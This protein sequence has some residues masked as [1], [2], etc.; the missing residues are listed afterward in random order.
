MA[1]ALWCGAVFAIYG[2]ALSVVVMRWFVE[3]DALSVVGLIGGVAG[4]LFGAALAWFARYCFRRWPPGD[5]LAAPPPVRVLVLILKAS[6]AAGVIAGLLRAV[7]G[8]FNWIGT[9]NSV[10]LGPFG[11]LLS[12]MA[13]CGLFLAL[14]SRRS[15]FLILPVV[16]VAVLGG[17][18]F[19]SP[20]YKAEVEKRVFL[21]LSV[22][23]LLVYLSL[24][25]R[26]RGRRGGDETPGAGPPPAGRPAPLQ[27][28]PHSLPAWVARRPC[29]G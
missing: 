2:L 21:V 1:E 16:V 10:C 11:G 24:F 9:I 14:T 26:L 6:T 20:Y 28:P 4:F 13:V 8:H 22:Q 19:L 7:W 25:V 5:P 29:S 17:S 12:G 18:W 23:L 27:P 15:V 3:A